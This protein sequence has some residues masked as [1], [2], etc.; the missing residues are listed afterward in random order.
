MYYQSLVNSIRPC[1]YLMLSLIGTSLSGQSVE[2]D[3]PWI[4]GPGITFYEL[5]TESRVGFGPS[6]VVNYRF[7][8]RFGIELMP[9]AILS[10]NGFRTFLGIAGDIGASVSWRHSQAE[11]IIGS[12]LSALT[13]VDGSGG[14]LGRGG[15]YLSGQGNLWLT[16]NVGLYGRFTARLWLIGHIS[17]EEYGRGSPSGSGGVVFR[18]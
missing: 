15:V 2:H 7:D 14:V 18:F 17:E 3:T 6:M 8:E 11:L 5:A 4:L 1:I 12:G 9:T 13:G 16:D 10:A